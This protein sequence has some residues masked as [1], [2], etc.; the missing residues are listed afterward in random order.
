MNES[1]EEQWAEVDTTEERNLHFRSARAKP[2]YLS[3]RV[4]L[5]HLNTARAGL[6]LQC[7]LAQCNFSFFPVDFFRTYQLIDVTVAG[8]HLGGDIGASSVSR[9]GSSAEMLSYLS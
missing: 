8:R 4:C 5:S 3:V 2:V 1:V 6:G 7:R 9:L